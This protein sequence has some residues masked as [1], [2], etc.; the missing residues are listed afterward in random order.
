[1]RILKTQMM[2]LRK[3]LMKGTKITYPNWN[4]NRWLVYDKKK[5]QIVDQ[6]G[7]DTHHTLL[8]LPENWKVLK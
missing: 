4:S 2:K 1:M 8:S 5:N 7:Y 6:N 3:L